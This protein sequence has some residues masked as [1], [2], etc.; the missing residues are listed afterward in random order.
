MRLVL[1]TLLLTARDACRSRVALHAEVLALRH[2]LLVLQRSRRS[3]LRLTDVDRGLWIAL[4]RLWTDWRSIL[5]RHPAAGRAPLSVRTARR[6]TVSP[7][8]EPFK[9]QTVVICALP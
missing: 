3:R 5:G 8:C 6:L 1:L 4:A 7:S 2:Q 9:A